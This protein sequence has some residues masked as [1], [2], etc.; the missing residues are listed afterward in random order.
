MADIVK[1][2]GSPHDK[3]QELLPWYVKGTLLAKEMAEV[4]A[5]LADCPICRKDLE[6]ERRL[7]GAIAE[8][9]LESE[10]A[11]SALQ[12]RLGG[13]PQMGPEAG[14]IAFPGRRVPVGWVL[15]S[16]LAAASAAA[17]LVLALPYRQPVG[18]TYVALGAPQRLR[19][20]NAVLMF[21]PETSERELRALLAGAGA[22]LVDGP[23][24]SGSYVVEIAPGRRDAALADLGKSPLI[25]V[26][27][28]IDIG[29]SP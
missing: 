3:A 26:A 10:R 22:R 15:S 17:I 13:S 12:S 6:A 8:L 18:Q 2:R 24:A 29:Q 9:P 28:P 23:T 21:K 19:T 14:R 11:W 25:V 5:H 7:A 20:G 4:E 16:S 27:Q 1:L